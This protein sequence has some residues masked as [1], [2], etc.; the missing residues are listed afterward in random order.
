M[1]KY[2]QCEIE[3]EVTGSW[4]QNS[5]WVHASSSES[6]VLLNHNARL[7]ETK[8]RNRRANTDQGD[9]EKAQKEETCTDGGGTPWVHSLI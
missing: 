8:E 6:C 5:T 3:S 1:S 4:T 2:P 9:R 7:S